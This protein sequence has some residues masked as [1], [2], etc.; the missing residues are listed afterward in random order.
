MKAI[1]RVG[2]VRG[3]G[4]VGSMAGHHNRSRQTLNAMPL[5]GLGPRFLIGSGNPGGDVRAR[6]EATACKQRKNGVTAVEVFLSATPEFFRPQEP[7]K[8]GTF[9]LNR[10]QAFCG[11]ALPWAQG[12]FGKDNIV[13]AVLHLDEATPH[14]HLTVTPIVF[15]NG[16]ARQSART[17]LNG[18]AALSKLQDSFAEAVAELGLRRGQRNSKA[19]HKEVSAWYGEQREV[20]AQQWDQAA[21]LVER[22]GTDVQLRQRAAQIRNPEIKLTPRN[23]PEKLKE[24]IDKRFGE[25]FRP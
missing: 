3:S 5:K 4:S 6:Y 13:S 24:E 15:L 8:Y 18:K 20:A 7:L 10:V 22:G 2:K 9:S 16:K 17:W 21:D 11:K 25:E 1:L 14:L 12:Y 19:H 23:M